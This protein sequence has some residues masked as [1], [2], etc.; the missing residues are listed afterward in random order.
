M[1]ANETCLC[2]FIPTL[3]FARASLLRHLGSGIVLL[4]L[5]ATG[6]FAQT[7]ITLEIPLVKPGKGPPTMPKR[8]TAEGKAVSPPLVW[9][10]LPKESRELALVFED[11]EGARV[12]WLVYSI[13]AKVPS[14]PE[15]LPNDEVLSEPSRLV[16]T[17]QG[18]TDF[19]QSGVGYIAP[20]TK[21]D[22]PQRYQ[23]TLFALDAKLGLQPG[24]DKASLMFLIQ[25]HIIGKGELI[26]TCGK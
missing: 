6:G 7:K 16:G 26:L 9:S 20:S 21:A 8:Y 11:L 10:Y 4:T 18:I 19:K 24:L 5:L 22:K 13:P 25:G 12:H 2:G 1:A 17:I 3:P 15:G 23:F 14:L